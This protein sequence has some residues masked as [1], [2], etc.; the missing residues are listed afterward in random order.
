MSKSPHFW[1]SIGMKPTLPIAAAVL[2][3]LVSACGG[4]PATRIDR[5]Y[6]SLDEDLPRIDPSILAG[7]RVVIDPGHGGRFRGTVGQDS[8]EESSVNLGVALYLWGLL[9]EAGADVYLTRATDRDFLTPEDS[10]LAADLGARVALADSIAPDVF[11]SIHHNAQPRRDPSVNLVETYYRPG[12][13]ASLELAFAIHRHL[14][15]NLGVSSGS[16]RQGNYFVLRENGVPSVL[17]ESSYLTHPPV[18]RRLRLAN[19]QRLEAESYFLG[20]LD[21]FSRGLP[22]ARFVSPVDSVLP[23]RTDVV[24]YA[25]DDAGGGIDAGTVDLRVNGRP[26]DPLVRPVRGD[27]V[28]IRWSLPAD[29]PN[30]DWR[31]RITVRNAGGNTSSVRTLRFR[32]E[33]PPASA[34]IRS[35]PPG[36]PASG[37]G[38]VWI[39]VRILD[40]R[41]IPVA[42]GTAVEASVND[43][44]VAHGV[45]SRGVFSF[46]APAAGNDPLRIVIRCG[47]R[48]FPATI[49]RSSRPDEPAWKARA[50][51]DRITGS[52]V[53]GARALI[54]APAGGA[55]GVV[56]TPVDR[57]ALVRAPGYRPLAIA[58]DAPDTLDLDPWF[59]G[60]LVGRRFVIDP[61]GG[62]GAG[63]GALG[64]ES[65]WVNLRVA[66][67]LSEYLRT[68]GA[69]VRITR[70]DEALR[71]PEDIARSTNAWGADRYIEIRHRALPA[72]SA[73]GLRAWHFPGSRTGARMALEVGTATARALGVPFV[74]AGATVTYA[75][76]QTACPAI[77]LSFP[78]I[79]DRREEL[80]LDRPAYRRAQA[81]AAFTGIVEHFGAPAGAVLEL[82]PARHRAPA[83][84]TLDDTWAVRVD[85]RMIRMPHLA[86]GDHVV[87]I[88]SAAGFV[89]R[90]F[91][92]AENDTIRMY[93]GRVGPDP[94]H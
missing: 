2:T 55:E 51:R 46:A 88:R 84:A 43:I 25:W 60:V 61:E 90:S 42:D 31:A 92:A 23:A 63:A 68:A 56:F 94:A 86:A 16:V 39:R 36:A 9:R 65:S 48:T 49:E 74:A 75:L 24:A 77:V 29:A 78:S 21:Y 53:R 83:L 3:V 11:L 27:T 20:L 19:V 70:R 26:V 82:I 4:P 10:S 66:G 32:V 62:S 28:E 69:H 22:R 12:D 73:P 1:Y 41:G 76:Q 89:R 93:A 57:G 50:V 17:G 59:G 33:Y 67:M 79:A 72:D 30:G 45:C 13:P 87:E 47:S 18:E 14:V 38:D 40:E 58:P 44:P 54:H 5:L 52:P 85:D 71:T 80:L 8:L 35:E 7:R 15:R 34:I 81:W 64:L 91:T 37:A 6:R